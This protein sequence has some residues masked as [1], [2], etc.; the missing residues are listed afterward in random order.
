[1]SLELHVDGERW[2]HHLR[3]AAQ[4][5]PGLVPVIKGNGYGFGRPGL[6]RRAEWL[7]A[8]EVAVGTYTEVPDA[9]SRFSGDV[10]VFTPWRPGTTAVSYDPRVIHTVG[11]VEDLHDLA[12]EAPSGSRVIVEGLTSMARHGFDRHALAEV[13]GAL[14]RLTLHGFA[15]HLPIAGSNLDEAERWIAALG[16]SK[17]AARFDGPATVYVSHLSDREIATLRERRPQFVLRPRVG[18]SLWLGD[19][20]ALSVTATVLDRHPVQRGERIGYRQRPMPRAGTVLVV[21]GGTAHG[22][23]LEAPSA[24]A[25]LRQRA[26]TVAR[27]GLEAAGLALSPFTVAGKQRW[28]VEPPH[29][30]ASML[31]LPA[32]VPPPQIGDRVEVDVRFTTTSFDVVRID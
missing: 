23:G 9:L 18:T 29:M 6:A 5:H 27:G 15:I 1:M 12:E 20:G 19:R 2:R 31:L 21:S 4:A 10:M 17:L 25:S 16:A 3:T 32:S 22:I 24:A 14:G 7:G 30:Q 28:F 11:R 26:G 13:S 8:S